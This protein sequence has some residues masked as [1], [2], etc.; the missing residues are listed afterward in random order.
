MRLMLFAGVL[1]AV[2][3]QVFAFP[4]NSLCLDTRTSFGGLIAT[5]VEQVGEPEG[6]QVSNWDTATLE[7]GWTSLDAG[8]ISKSVCVLNETALVHGGRLTEDETW[9]ADVIHVIR[10]NVVV[11]SGK[12]LTLA[13]GAVV[14]FTEGAQIAAEGSGEV[15]LLGAQCAD[16]AD[17]TVG[18]DTNF[19]AER[20]SPT[21]DFADWFGDG[22][23]PLSVSFI[24][25]DNERF[26]TC[27]YSFGITI[28]ALPTPVRDGYTF[29]GW[30]T[31]AE[32]GEQ[33]TE[34]TV[35]AGN[36]TYYV[37][38]KQNAP[39]PAPSPVPAPNPNPEPTPEPKPVKPELGVG[40]YSYK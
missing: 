31:A 3:A 34:S 18:G 23:F 33:I 16:I 5:G 32:G 30:F 6:A 38:W 9:A 21:T 8:S 15:F 1:L 29:L 14:K 10:G 19:D 20:S 25:H 11:P 2:A 22:V 17:D 35:V 40:D 13:S 28:G 7:D 12:T 27:Y 37:H 39:N 26:S 4:S 36:V 24:S